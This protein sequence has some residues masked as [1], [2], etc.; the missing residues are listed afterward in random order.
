MIKFQEEIKK[1][2]RLMLEPCVRDE[3]Q[4]WVTYINSETEVFSMCVEVLKALLMEQ[5]VVEN[6]NIIATLDTFKN[7]VFSTIGEQLQ[8]LNEVFALAATRKRREALK[9]L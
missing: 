9:D 1:C 5:Q 7:E 2:P 6:I 8:Q 3:C 4:M